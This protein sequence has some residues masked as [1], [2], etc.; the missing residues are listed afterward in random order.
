MAFPTT[1][2]LDD[3]NRADEN[4][5]SFGGKWAARAGTASDSQLQIISNVVAWGAAAGALG[6]RYW[7]D[8]TF[9]PDCE[10]YATVTTLSGT[11]ADYV[12]MWLRLDTPGASAENGYMM[13]WSNDANGCRIFKENTRESYTQLAQAAA[14]RFTTND[15]IGFEAI[16]TA[17]TVYKN[18]VSVLTITDA[19]HAGAGNIALGIRNNVTRLDNF[20][21]GTTVTSTAKPKPLMT[22]GVG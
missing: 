15:Q 20:G 1:G 22:L 6:S 17:L 9:G 14:A 13:Q 16:G 3:F 10:V 18:G 4:P 11:A 8:S 7:A 12:R 19:T 2:I 5:L 21:G